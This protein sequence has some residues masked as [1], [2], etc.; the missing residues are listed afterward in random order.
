M[1][2]FDNVRH[3]VGLLPPFPLT[4]STNQANSAD[5]K[6]DQT[7]HH[8][9]R[10]NQWIEPWFRSRIGREVGD[11][12]SKACDGDGNGEHTDEDKEDICQE[13]FSLRTHLY[14]RALELRKDANHCRA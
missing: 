12:V 9:Q 11:V 6:E 3:L 2:P 14:L 8:D 4:E 7:D 5:D 1:F 10:A 13:R